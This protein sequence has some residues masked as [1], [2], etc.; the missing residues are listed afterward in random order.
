ML[1][2]E[3]VTIIKEVKTTESITLLEVNIKGQQK[4]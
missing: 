2:I 3:S 4:I 1:I